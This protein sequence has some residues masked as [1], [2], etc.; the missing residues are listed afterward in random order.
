MRNTLF[1]PFERLK[2]GVFV[3]VSS[4]MWYNSKTIVMRYDYDYFTCKTTDTQLRKHR[5]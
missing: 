3:A 5:R 4:I 2:Q 1:Q